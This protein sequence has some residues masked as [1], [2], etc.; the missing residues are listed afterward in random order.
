MGGRKQHN[1]V[2]Q[3]ASD[4]LFLIRKKKTKVMLHVLKRIRSRTHLVNNKKLGLTMYTAL[5]RGFLKVM[6]T[7][8]G[9][10]FLFRPIKR[11]MVIRF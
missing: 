4:F 8:L 1:I 11:I 3:L 7:L 5:R 6:H 10:L 2:K 9:L